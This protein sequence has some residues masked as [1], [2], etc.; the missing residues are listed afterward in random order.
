MP[1]IFFADEG[2]YNPTREE[3]KG[4]RERKNEKSK[5]VKT[6]RAVATAGTPVA[7]DTL[8]MIS[9]AVEIP[10]AGGGVDEKAEGNM[11]LFLFYFFICISYICCYGTRN[12]IKR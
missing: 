12:G 1:G 7:E 8:T 5:G 9:H 10:I 11:G 6:A 2:S 4:P 3:A